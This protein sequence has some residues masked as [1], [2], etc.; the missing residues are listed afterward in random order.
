MLD[1]PSLGLA[2]KIIG[3]LFETITELKKSIPIL[4]VEQNASA[5]LRIADY[6]YVI[7]NGYTTMQDEAKYLLGKDEV[8]AKY[9][10]G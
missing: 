6:G 10:G 4:L 1:E 7:E 9:L 2:P 8:R 5:A 3:E